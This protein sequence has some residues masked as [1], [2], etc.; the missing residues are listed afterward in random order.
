MPKQNG[1]GMNFYAGIYNVSGDINSLGS[2]SASV[3]TL[4]KT[5][6]DKFG[7]ER[8]QGLSTGTIEFVSHFNVDAGREHV[9]FKS[10]P[11]A[12]VILSAFI[13]TTLGTPAAS[14]VAKQLNYD[15]SRS[16]DGDIKFSLT[17]NSNGYGL[18]WGRALTAGIR[19][20]TAATNGSSIDTTASASFGGQAYLH[21]TAFS[22]TDVT[23]KIQDSADNSS[24]SDVTSFT[25]GTITGT[26][27]A[28]IQLGATAT[29]RRYLRAVTT[30]SAGF[31]SVSFA[32]N[33]VKNTATIG[34]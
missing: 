20:D 12:D 34:F 6:I 5:G 1:L 22:G 8:I 11:T 19:T 7:Y 29:V 31:T 9:A 13:S 18:E 32:I 33:V 16:D 24:W 27:S 15:A 10:L 3:S 23:I 25:F 4:D 30:T 2:I 21:V 26:T 17:G 28:R 14:M